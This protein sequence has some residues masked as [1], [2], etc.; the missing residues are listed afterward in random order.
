[1]TRLNSPQ[2]SPQVRHSLWDQGQGA[3]QL[4]GRR[5]GVVSQEPFENVSWIFNYKRAASHVT[6]SI[7]K[8]QVLQGLDFLQI[9]TRGKY[10][11]AFL[12][13]KSKAMASQRILWLQNLLFETH[14][15]GANAGTSNLW[16][17]V[18]LWGTDQFSSPGINGHPTPEPRFPL[19]E[20]TTVGQ[21][22]AVAYKYLQPH[23][24]GLVY[25]PLGERQPW[26]ASF[27]SLPVFVAKHSNTF[28]FCFVT[29]FP[30]LLT[31]FFSL[32]KWL[33]GLTFILD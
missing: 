3:E 9:F 6:S 11:D 1:M 16:H 18:P 12:C 32:T 8:K 28:I 19:M 13:S 33:P 15:W 31:F 29:W 14:L 21:E 27:Q 10:S 24:G 22:K 26:H 17:A 4:G 23:V 7:L 2:D 30:I 5:S 25:P 20:R